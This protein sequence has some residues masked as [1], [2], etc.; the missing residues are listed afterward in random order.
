MCRQHQRRDRVATQKLTAQPEIMAEAVEAVA[1]ERV[2]PHPAQAEL[3]AEPVPVV[4]AVESLVVAVLIT[5]EEMAVPGQL[6]YLQFHLIRFMR[7]CREVKEEVEPE[8]QVRQEAEVL[9]VLILSLREWETE[10]EETE[11][12]EVIRQVLLAEPE[13]PEATEVVPQVLS[14]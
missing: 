4:E 6:I 1:K 11:H 10:P 9:L 5:P 8:G 13:E 3:V 14:Y 12:Q 7:E 2:E